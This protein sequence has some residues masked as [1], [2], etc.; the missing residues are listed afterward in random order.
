[1]PRKRAADSPAR[2][3][4]LGQET[5]YVGVDVG[6]RSHVAGFLSSTLL[7][8]HQR[9]EHCPT[10]S[11]ENSRERFRTLV[12][13]I[14]EYTPLTQVY[15]LLESTGHYHRALMQYAQELDIPVFLIHVQK[16]PQRIMKTDKRDALG[17]ANILYNQ[18][19]K[20]I[21]VDDP[22]QAV[23][24]L[25]PPTD[26]AARLR[27]MVRHHYELV[28]ECTQRKNKLTSICDELF[29]EFTRLL[30]N[31]NLPT[32]LALRERFPTPALLAQ[33]SFEELRE[34]RGRTNSVSDAKLRQLKQLAAQSIGSKAPARV[35]GLVFEQKQLIAELKLLGQHIE[36]LEAEIVQIVEQ[37]REGK[38]L[39]SIPGIG[40]QAAATLI[41]MIGTI[42]NFEHA[43]QLK[44]YA[45]WVPKVAQSGSSLDWTRLSPRG[46]RQMK[47]TMYLIVWRAIQWDADWKEMY[48]SLIVRK[49]RVDERTRRLV[50]RE[51]VIGRL[52]GQMLS[53]IYALL[54]KDYELLDQLPLGATLPEPQLYDPEIH[55]KHR[56]GHYRPTKPGVR[57]YGEIRFPG[58]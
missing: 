20:G 36:Q 41:A 45:D 16:R 44:S 11:F 49:C 8:R 56:Q 42:A 39:T 38:I 37:C 22:L 52:A 50:G 7:T 19:A 5:L 32:A 25:A 15:L 57:P 17:L 23:R 43:A 40:S 34:A 3:T 48:D 28:M 30:K 18:L 9:F 26:A 51:K 4:H 31:P 55:R 27:G 47:Q 12:D 6:K 1:M 29:P 10:F 53:V 21:Q 46:V 35:Q 54:K 2:D 24:R 14:Q 33:A 13:R 58:D